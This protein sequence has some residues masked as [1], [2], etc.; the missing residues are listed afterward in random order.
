MKTGV[1]PQLFVGRLT[2]YFSTLHSFAVRKELGCVHLSLFSSDF[3]GLPWDIVT[4]R[5]VASVLCAV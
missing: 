4:P 2:G 3:I 5:D 1:W